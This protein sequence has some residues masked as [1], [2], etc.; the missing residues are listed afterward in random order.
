MWYIFEAHNLKT[1]KP[2]H[3]EQ[4][5]FF[6]PHNYMWI[7]NLQFADLREHTPACYHPD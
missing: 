3:S 4:I 7:Q 2:E 5:L 1:S 6:L